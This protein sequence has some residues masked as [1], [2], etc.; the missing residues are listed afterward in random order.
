MANPFTQLREAVQATVATVTGVEWTEPYHGETPDLVLQRLG[1]SGLSGVF[2][3]VVA[4]TKDQ[5]SSKVRD[6]TDV[7]VHLIVAAAN[8]R[9][10]EAVGEAA[11]E[12][13]WDVYST[14]SQNKCNL[15]WLFCGLQLREW[16]TV[17]Q[18]PQGAVISVIMATR[19]DMRE[20]IEA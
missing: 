8:L 11:E 7:L 20:W 19:F 9:S 5:E 15:S 18:T 2:V 6:D 16:E 10:R 1:R 14:M 13:L 12:L 3:R 17:A 4:G